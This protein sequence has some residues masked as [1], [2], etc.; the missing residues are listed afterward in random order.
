MATTNATINVQ[1]NG[2]QQLDKLDRAM[3]AI[4]AKFTGLKAQLAGLG[5]A[6]FG[7]SA[8]LAADGLVDLS[9]ATGIAIGRLLELQGAVQEAGGKADAMANG[10]LKFVQTIDEAAQGSLK[11]QAGFESLGISLKDLGTLSEEQLLLRVLDEIGKVTDKSRQAGLMMEY[12]GKSMRGVSP[13]KLRDDLQKTK[14]T[15]DEFALSVQRAADIQGKLDK[16]VKNLGIAFLVVVEPIVNFINKISENQGKIDQLVVLLKTLGVVL[17]TVFGGGAMLAAIR[18]IAGLG[19][20]IGALGQLMGRFSA[21]LAKFGDDIVKTLNPNGMVM[22]ALRSAGALIGSVAAGVAAFF[23]LGGNKEPAADTTATDAE[24]K[25]NEEAAKAAQKTRDIDTS[26]RKKALES[27]RD[28]SREYEKQQN[29][30]VNRLDTETML[31][32]KSDE[33]RQMLEAQRNL[34]EDYAR[35]Q[36]DLIKKKRDLS[37]EDQYQA[38]EIDKLIKRNAELYTQQQ[39]GLTNAINRNQTALA[40]EKE[41]QATLERITQQLERQAKL[42]EAMLKIRQDTN[43]ALRDVKFEGEQMG[44]TPLERSFAQI[45]ENARK[46]A[47]EAGRAFAQQFEGLELSAEEAQTLANGLGLI[48]KQYQ[49][50]AEEQT[51]NLVKSR[52]W[53]TGWTDAFNQYMDNATNAARMA[54]DMFNAITGNMNSAIDNFVKTGKFS[55]KDFARSV[56]QDL[57]AM[58]LKFLAAKWLKGDFSSGG[59][60]LGGVMKLF[61]FANGGNPPIN[62]PS[63]VGE[64]GPE[65]FVPK[66][67]GTIIPNDKLGGV[68]G[69]V[70]NTYI[71]NNISALD[72][73]SVAALFADNRKTL[74][75]TVELARKEM[76]Y[77]NR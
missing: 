77:Y 35:V 37:Q 12:F 11:A 6:A 7:R 31:V 25:A 65:L 23:G 48:A 14:G 30:V 75:G 1:V 10:I 64:E 59:G 49:L 13:D 61:G 3:S 41:R 55:F 39:Q 28:I 26:N 70:Q 8:I 19:R 43:A 67:A 27:L 52:E 4:G 58:E 60:I 73:K 44:R 24:T 69:M 57:A 72:A 16:A 32:G 68:S 76:P 51:K 5:L 74:L 22:R 18:V 47:E 17:A 33:E 63:V 54:G 45:Q 66:T 29:L 9:D 46:A 36:E 38:A 56:L 53:A 15:M 71:T 2:L 42:D 21:P 40:L 34:A 62:R 50:I 20:G